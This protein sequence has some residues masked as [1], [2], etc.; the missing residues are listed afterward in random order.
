VA[1]TVAVIG[2]VL[3]PVTALAQFE[4][5]LQDPGFSQPAASTSAQLAYKA[6]T[7]VGGSTI[8]LNFNWQTIAP[9][10]ATAPAGFDAANPGDPLYNW[11]AIDAAVRTAAAHHDHVLAD[12]VRAPKWA[13]PAGRPASLTIFGG[14]WNPSVQDFSLF[15]RAAAMRYSGHYVPAGQ[16]SPLPRV[17]QW[18]IWNEENL[19]ED[20]T[21]PNL[22]SE[23][24]SLL[25]AG[26]SA[27]KSASSSNTVIMGG[28]A[29][30]SFVNGISVSPLKFAAEVMCLQRV[31]TRFIRAKACPVK[32]HF[33][34]LAIH[35]YSLDATPT[36]HAYSYDDILVGDVGKLD[37]LLSAAERLNT[38]APHI[39]YK[40]WADEW[41]WFTNP[42]DKQVGDAPHTAARYTAYSM[43]EMWRDG[44]SLVVWFRAEDPSTPPPN[45]PSFINGGGLYTSTGTPKPMMQ[46]FDF[47]VVAGISRGQGFVWGR[48]PVSR[49]TEV[50]IEHKV[51]GTW[52]R[53]MTANTASDGVFEVHFAATH[54]G[55]YRAQI[56]HSLVSLGYNSEPIA[57]VRT[58]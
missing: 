55:S 7:A 51:G 15:A 6:L 52:R 33:D 24:R 42:P 37:T 25:N 38:A 36:K 2:L 43:Y 8:R 32:A 26:Y 9:S 21:A 5:G 54:N 20:L 56:P 45:S 31:G 34:V 10:G 12:L 47:P 4:V 44:V 57:P 13:Q 30:V 28:L 19:P 16:T 40:L 27:V 48:A 53:L 46:A 22:V 41:S 58:H 50:V 49:R 23:Y 14:I 3:V 18:E 29:P 39:K 35:P 17:S 11:D 1:V